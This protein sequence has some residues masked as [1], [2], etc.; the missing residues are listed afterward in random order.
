M[1]NHEVKRKNSKFTWVPMEPV[2]P[3]IEI[4]LGPF[5]FLVP[6]WTA[7]VPGHAEG[8]G[9]AAHWIPFPHVTLLSFLLKENPPTKTPKDTN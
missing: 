9:A 3:M 5:Q 6:G 7:A 2:D 8:G 4:G 1:Q